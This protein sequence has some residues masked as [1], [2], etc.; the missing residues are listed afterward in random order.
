MSSSDGPTQ[1]DECMSNLG[2]SDTSQG[3]SSDCS[4]GKH[5]TE[6]PRMNR[7]KE[8][9]TVSKALREPAAYSLTCVDCLVLVSARVGITE[10]Q[11]QFSCCSI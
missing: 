1:L 9:S 4:D 2:S 10:A 5:A 8:R 11:T 6:E 3:N 7:R